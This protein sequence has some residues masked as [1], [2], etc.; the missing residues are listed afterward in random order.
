MTCAFRRGG[1]TPEWML[2]AG[3]LGR[4]SIRLLTGVETS[5]RRTRVSSMSVLSDGWQNPAAAGVE[6]SA[7]RTGRFMSP[8]HR[9]GVPLWKRRASCLFAD[10]R[11]ALV[12]FY[13][14]NLI[15]NQ[16]IL[17]LLGSAGK[18]SGESTV[19][20][21]TRSFVSR[22]LSAV[23]GLFAAATMLIAVPAHANPPTAYDSGLSAPFEVPDSAVGCTRSIWAMVQRRTAVH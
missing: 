19:R 8:S 21:R 13:D 7:Q 4:M 3:R 18:D 23:I 20:V 2:S 9:R 12:R 10:R 11:S 5:V 17:R 1:S 6:T 22:T 14:C 16:R 15:E